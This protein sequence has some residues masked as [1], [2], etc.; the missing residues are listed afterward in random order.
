MLFVSYF[1]IARQ[2]TVIFRPVNALNVLC[3]QLTRDLS[4][5]AKFLFLFYQGLHIIYKVCF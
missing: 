5:I 1:I 4:A 2:H 3:A